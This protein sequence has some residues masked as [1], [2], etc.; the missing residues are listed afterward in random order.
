MK[1]LIA[2]LLLVPVLSACG[3]DPGG[4]TADDPAPEPTTVEP[5]LVQ[6]IVLTSAGGEVSTRAYF[7]DER[8][9]M[10]AYVRTFHDRKDVI[11]AI[12]QGVEDAGEREGRLAVAT[13]AVGCDVPEGVNVTEGEDGWEVVAGKIVD[14]KQECYAPMTTIAL[15]EIP[16][17]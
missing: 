4:A 1:R 15:V 16:E 5:T 3:D 6:P 8:A 11:A 7:V 14:P 13:V 2:A 12:Q 17:E 9:D 10:K